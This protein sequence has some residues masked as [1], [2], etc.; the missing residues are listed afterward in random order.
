MF[1][2]EPETTCNPVQRLIAVNLYQ[3]PFHRLP[4]TKARFRTAPISTGTDTT[5]E[6]FFFSSHFRKDY[7]MDSFSSLLKKMLTNNY[8]KET[9]I[10][11]TVILQFYISRV[12]TYFQLLNKSQSYL[13]L[14]Y[15]L[16]K[17]ILFDLFVIRLFD[18]VKYNKYKK[19][20]MDSRKNKEENRRKNM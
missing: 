15:L 5:S 4:N 7:N 18:I 9:N 10:L 12:M 13:C 8:I 6:R 16:Q 19:S 2:A 3:S 14:T 17:I 1:A 11:K 20:I